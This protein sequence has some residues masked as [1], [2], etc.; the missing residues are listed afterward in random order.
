MNQPCMLLK[1]S[2]TPI[3]SI[4]IDNNIDNGFGIN[5]NIDNDIA[6]VFKIDTNSITVS[7]TIAIMALILM[8][9]VVSMS[10]T[11]QKWYL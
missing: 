10:I 6:L 5:S 7:M 3:S 2:F 4:Y 1:C 8:S 11:A 9:I